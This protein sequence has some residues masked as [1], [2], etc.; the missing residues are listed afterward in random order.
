MQQYDFKSKGAQ[1]RSWIQLLEEGEK[2]QSF[3]LT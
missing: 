2:N 3:S 1:I